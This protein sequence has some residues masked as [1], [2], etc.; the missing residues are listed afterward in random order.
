MSEHFRHPINIFILSGALRIDLFFF[1]YHPIILFYNSAAFFSLETNK[2]AFYPV[3]A[4]A[5]PCPPI[6]R[7]RQKDKRNILKYKRHRSLANF[8][9]FISILYVF[10]SKTLCL[11]FRFG[12]KAEPLPLR[13][14]MRLLSLL[15][16]LICLFFLDF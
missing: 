16:S 4:M 5:L 10:L 2:D 9:A 11:I 3:G 1:R 15:S 7:F 13:S 6:E 8:F 12:G 14:S